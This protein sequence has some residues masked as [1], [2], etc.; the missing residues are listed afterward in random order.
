MGLCVRQQWLMFHRP[1]T[2]TKRELLMLHLTVC[3]YV[4]CV[5]CS[6]LF[7]PTNALYILTNYFYIVSTPT[8]LDA[9]ASCLGSN[10]FCF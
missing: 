6:L 1:F 8:R 3:M 5:L 2:A 10:I 4:A 7:R 9:F